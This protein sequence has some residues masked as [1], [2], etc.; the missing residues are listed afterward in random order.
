MAHIRN[1]AKLDD[2]AAIFSPSVARIAASTA[3]D[4]SYL[5]S[6]LRAKL[7]LPLDRPLPTFERNSDT[8]KALLAFA[9]FSEAADEER[10]LVARSEAEA[11]RNLSSASRADRGTSVR[12]V[13]LE[14]I[15]DELPKDGKMALEGMAAMAVQAG[16]IFPEPEDLGRQILD[17][18]KA[19]F[20]AEQMKSRAEAL[21]RHIA[22]DATATETLG[23][24]LRGEEYTP[25]P[26]LAK[27]NLDQQRK[28][29]IS[30]T[31][32]P[33][34]QDRVASLATSHDAT[35]YPTIQDIVAEEKEF[36]E[37]LGRK[38]QLDLQLT[39]FEGL[40]GD[41][42][43]ARSEL[44]VMQEQLK[45]ATTRRDAVFEGLVERESPVRRRR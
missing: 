25:R 8:L 18:Q 6:W 21:S 42:D 28:V 27:Q 40:P 16:I 31:Q 38:R 1:L 20:E 39:A 7:Q 41:L 45:G 22:S 11:L 30:A 34:L 3:R 29:K 37:L 14:A 2:S 12:D 19:A 23:N 32:L 4:W 26:G 13:L 5:D 24:R 44:E 15:E 9:S 36:L 43:M 33:D 10:H 35:S 17:H